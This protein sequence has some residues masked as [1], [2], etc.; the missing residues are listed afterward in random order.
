MRA[1]RA[2]LRQM[3]EAAG[4]ADITQL[5]RKAGIAHTTLTRVMSANDED[6]TWKLS[7]STWMKLSQASGVPIT[8]LGD[9]IIVEDAK[10]GARDPEAQRRRARL[11]MWWDSLSAAEQE[12]FFR[13]LTSW[14]RRTD[15][16]SQVS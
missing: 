11:L 1:T 13:L 2:A 10:P 4:A 12:H 5:A 3:M 15:G 14:S 9:S 16:A 8:F 6:I 7:A